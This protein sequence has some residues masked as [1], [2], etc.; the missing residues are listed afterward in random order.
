MVNKFEI[1]P[2]D[3]K[4][5]HGEYAIMPLY[6]SK[7]DRAFDKM[8]IHPKVIEIIKRVKHGATFCS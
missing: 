8:A 6:E 3:A 7:T 4:G 2:I 1:K 5:V